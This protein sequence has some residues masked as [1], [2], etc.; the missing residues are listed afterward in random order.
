MLGSRKDQPSHRLFSESLCSL[1]GQLTGWKSWG[2]C[3]RSHQLW[4]DLR[5]TCF[6]CKMDLRISH[7]P[8]MVAQT[9]NSR[10][11]EVEAGRFLCI[12]GQPGV[13]RKL[14][15]NQGYIVS[16]SQNIFKK[17]KRGTDVVSQW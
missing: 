3:H 9:F 11:R 6:I 14:Q 15:A 10:T 12:L 5:L 13:Q 1:Q 2:D 4:Q 16:L 8:D 17:I 7:G